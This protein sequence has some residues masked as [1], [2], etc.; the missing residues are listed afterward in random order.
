ML[1]Y[2]RFI[3]KENVQIT[4]SVWDLLTILTGFKK[5]LQK[6][7]SIMLARIILVDFSHDTWGWAPVLGPA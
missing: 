3:E 4:N 7:T 2:C 1:D 5:T 6:T